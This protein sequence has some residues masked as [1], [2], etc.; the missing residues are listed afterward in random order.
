MTDAREEAWD[1]VRGMSRANV[2]RGLSAA[3]LARVV[4]RAPAT[5]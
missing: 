1:A 3:E 5:R 4:D 2:G